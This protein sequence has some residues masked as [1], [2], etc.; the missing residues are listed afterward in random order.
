[1]YIAPNVKGYRLPNGTKDTIEFRNGKAYY[2]QRAKKY[3]LV[4]EDIATLVTSGTNVDYVGVPLSKFIPSVSPQGITTADGSFIVENFNGELANESIDGAT[5]NVGKIKTTDVS[6]FLILAKGTYANLTAAQAALAGKV[7]YYQLATPITTEIDADG[8]LNGY[9][10]GTVYIENAVKDMAI[11]NSGFTIT[12]DDYLISELETIVKVDKITGLQTVYSASNAVVA[13]DKL[14]FTH[15]S[16]ANGDLVFIT[17]K[18]ASPLMSNT[19]ITFID[20]KQV[21]LGTGSSAGKYL[22]I[23]PSVVNGSIVW[24]ATEV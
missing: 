13:G 19:T 14:S 12:N 24:V 9:E 23:T 8:V 21:V 6:L 4:S 1:M 22:K 10:N 18:Y 2:V 7:I 3:T 15:S 20:N 17:Y 16:L 5:A 11:Y